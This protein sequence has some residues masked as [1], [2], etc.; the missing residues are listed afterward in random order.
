M[1]ATRVQREEEQ[2]R[3]LS[4]FIRR[5]TKLALASVKSGESAEHVEREVQRKPTGEIPC[6]S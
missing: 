3:K 2:A 6:E 5:A 4:R 1:G